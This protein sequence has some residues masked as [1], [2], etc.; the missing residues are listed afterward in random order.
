MN[1]DRRDEGPELVTGAEIARRLD[2]SRERVRQWA[3]S[4]TLGFPPP[5]N[6]KGRYIVWDW[7]P[8][9]T[10]AERRRDS[11]LVVSWT[12]RHRAAIADTQA[13]ARREDSATAVRGTVVSDVRLQE[14]SVDA[15]RGFEPGR[16]L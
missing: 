14:G 12:A 9:A 15:D 3:A 8:V 7:Q 6:R 5:V 1:P 16:V 11:P 13:G 4:P 2:R 10:W